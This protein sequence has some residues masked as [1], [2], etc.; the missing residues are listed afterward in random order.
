MTTSTEEN[1]LKSIYHLSVGHPNPVL[2]SEI[3]DSLTTSSAS[4]TDMLKKLSEKNLIEYERYKGVRI[5]RKGER[6]A[7]S[8]IRRHRLWE[9]FLTDVLKFRWDEVHEMA[10]ELE[11]VSSDELVSRLDAFLGYP[12][13]D[14]H[15]DPIPDTNG[16][17]LPSGSLSLAEAQTAQKY[18]VSG[19]SDHS[20]GF[21]QFLQKKGLMPGVLFSVKEIDEFDKSMY[22]LFEDNSGTFISHEIAKNILMKL[23]VNS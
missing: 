11:H 7:L 1:Y 15:G 13:V 21:L 10:E 6:V 19:V 18:Q 17:L 4:V 14:P 5:T 16:K 3:A 8:I 9:V 23:Y 22:L 12:K 2:T 20:A